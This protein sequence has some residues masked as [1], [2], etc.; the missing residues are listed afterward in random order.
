MMSSR[1]SGRS[2]KKVFSESSKKIGE[3]FDRVTKVKKKCIYFFNEGSQQ[4]I[5]L[6][7]IKG[8]DICETTRLGGP[9]PP[10]YVITT[11]ICKDY[12][13]PNTEEALKVKQNFEKES[14][15]AVKELEKQTGKRFDNIGRD[16]KCNEGAIPLFLA[17]RTS[18]V[19]IMPGMSD[20]ILNIGINDDTV[21][22]IARITKNPRWAFDTYRTFIQMFG[23]VAL[24]IDK[25]EYTDIIQSFLKKRE[26][27]DD[28]KLPLVDIQ[29][30]VEEFK[31]FTEFPQD[32]WEQ[33]TKAIQAVYASWASP[34]FK[35]YRDVHWIDK[36]MGIA[37]IVQTMVYGNMNAHSGAGVVYSR[38]PNDGTKEFYGE[39]LPGSET[40]YIGSGGLT[41]MDITAFSKEHHL[42]YD[43]LVEIVYALEKHFKT[44][45]M[46]E[47]T[48]E[49]NVLYLLQT[50]TG[51]RS[52]EA[53]VRIAV[54]LVYEGLITEREALLRVDAGNMD[55]VFKRIIDPT[56][57]K[58]SLY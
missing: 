11:E 4:D 24:G 27:K 37:V 22:I 40:H 50:S 5:G 21:Q 12:F 7:G 54:E 45:Q 58:F 35:T 29:A 20:T 25:Q 30:I 19:Q 33:L 42:T 3:W 36:N 53:G 18:T 15:E 34:R 31:S 9:V 47:F 17:V 51:R 13:N 10:G 56:N 49:S 14:V 55:Y 2:S 44:M 57:S 43:R 32:P 39:Y 23:T 1:K 52:P 26:V 6:L 48:L 38:N 41:P 28:S 16:V 46:V 8:A